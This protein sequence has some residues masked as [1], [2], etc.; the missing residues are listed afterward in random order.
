MNLKQYRLKQKLSVIEMAR[1]IKVTRQHVYEIESKSDTRP[2][3]KL[4]K[5]IER[6]T[7][8][9]VTAKELLGV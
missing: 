2:S 9:E 6:K 8:G 4:A 3:V 5:I 1:I 7:N